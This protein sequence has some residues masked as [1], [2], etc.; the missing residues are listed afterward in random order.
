MLIICTGSIYNWTLLHVYTI[1][2]VFK[3][4]KKYLTFFLAFS[5]QSAKQKETTYIS[6]CFENL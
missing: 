3:K 1:T 4:I 5:K 6:S 2:V